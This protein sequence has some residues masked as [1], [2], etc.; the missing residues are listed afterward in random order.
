MIT[1]ASCSSS[2]FSFLFQ[3]KFFQIPASEILTSNYLQE[4]MQ[5]TMNTLCPPGRKLGQFVI[6]FEG[7][8]KGKGSSNCFCINKVLEFNLYMGKTQQR[9]EGI[10]KES[11]N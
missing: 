3:E 9:N 7:G 8:W 1:Y 5:M 2:Y 10:C 6:V 4:K 11:S